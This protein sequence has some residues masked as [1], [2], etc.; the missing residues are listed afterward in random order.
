[1]KLGD[2]KEG[3]DMVDILKKISIRELRGNK[4]QKNGFLE[5]FAETV[6]KKF[7]FLH[8]GRRRWGIII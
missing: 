4:C 8:N 1:M 5:I 7:D 2:N 3:S 6:Y